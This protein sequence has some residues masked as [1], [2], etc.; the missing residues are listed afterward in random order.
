MSRS[1]SSIRTDSSCS[2]V[3]GVIA[4]HLIEQLLA[5]GYKVRGTTRTAS[6]LD[7][8]KSKWDAKYPDQFEVAE[9]K[10]ITVDGAFDEA[11]K[12]TFPNSS[13]S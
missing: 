8:L 3:Q 7:S 12:G 11:I 4:S 2:N 5:L 6:K 1:L 9:V 10:D 13:S